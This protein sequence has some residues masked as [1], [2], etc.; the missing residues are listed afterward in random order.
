MLKV[1]FLVR[2]LDSGGAERQLVQ[3]VRL[4]D[5]RQFAV[6]VA[7][8]YDGGTL[9]PDMAALPD[10]TLI[11]LGKQRR[12]D[13]AGFVYRLIRT[14]RRA[15]PDIVVGYMN[16]ANEFALL[17]GRA[18]GAKVVWN[19]RSAYVDFSK[20]D[21]P[22]RM[23]FRLGAW[24]SR[25]PDAIIANSNAGSRHHQANGYRREGMTI[26]VNGIDT[27][28]FV[29]QPDEG[30]RVRQELG[31]PADATLVGMVA[32]LDPIKDHELYIEAAAL[33]AQ[34][35]RD[36]R[37]IC[38][39]DG[40]ES[41]GQRLHELGSRRG[42]DGRLTWAGNRR[43][44]PAVYSALDIGVC[45]SIGEG[46]PNAV[47]EGMAAGVPQAV[48]DVGDSATIVGP[49]GE[50]C[51][52]RDPEELAATIERLLDRLS[53]QLRIQAR[54]RIE[55]LFSFER[56]RQDFEKRLRSVART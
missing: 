42:L 56:F 27:A 17:A 15:S 37:F 43:D 13:I 22:S 6:T 1:F 52:R 12:W 47:A 31:I 11:S 21:W 55:A 45:S 46:F 23:V 32:R 20:Y 16:V 10:T 48:T 24:L 33:V 7:T 50:V 19:L 40:P 34:R 49:T 51:R 2:S 18:A 28:Q 9:R 26:V 25:F 29:R 14:A 53:G 41:Y 44:M 39:G 54:A 36:V 8:F 30:K 4:L 38:V 5:R 3:L 35:R